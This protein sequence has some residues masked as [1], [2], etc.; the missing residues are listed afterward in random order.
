MTNGTARG[1]GKSTSVRLISPSPIQFKLLASPVVALNI[2]FFHSCL[3]LPATGG[4][5]SSEGAQHSQKEEK[6]RARTGEKRS[7][8]S[9]SFSAGLFSSPLLFFLPSFIVA[10]ALL[11]H[12]HAN[13]RSFLTAT[14]LAHPLLIFRSSPRLRLL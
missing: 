9:L 12:T 5:T 7:Q 11:T 6:R 8:L 4:R 14:S 13:T 3:S 10:D 1:K 2:H